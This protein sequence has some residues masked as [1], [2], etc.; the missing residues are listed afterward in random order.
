MTAPRIWITL[1]RAWSCIDDPGII[2]ARELIHLVPPKI[3]MFEWGRWIFQQ[4]LELLIDEKKDD[5]THLESFRYVHTSI[6][7][8]I[9]PSIHLWC[10]CNSPSRCHEAGEDLGVGRYLR[11]WNGRVGEFHC[12][13]WEFNF[14]QTRWF[15]AGWC[16]DLSGKLTIVFTRK[17]GIWLD[18][19]YKWNINGDINDMGIRLWIKLTTQRRDITGKIFSRGTVL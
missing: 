7:P 19:G 11:I 8:S 9:Y 16:G 12:E 13:D 10:R 18:M 1:G 4:D 2:I 6:H 17:M 15:L 5:Y 3:W 14:K